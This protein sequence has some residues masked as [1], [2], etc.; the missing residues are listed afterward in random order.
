MN[1]LKFDEIKAKSFHVRSVT[2]LGKPRPGPNHRVSVL[3]TIGSVRERNETKYNEFKEIAWKIR[4]SQKLNYWVGFDGHKL[5]IKQK[6]M[7]VPQSLAGK[8]LTFGF[9]PSMILSQLQME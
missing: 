1:C 5:V 3:V 6:K 7:R 9:L 4:S 2:A 8:S